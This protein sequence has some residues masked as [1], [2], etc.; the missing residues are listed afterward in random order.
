MEVLLVFI[1]SAVWF[2]LVLAAP[3]VRRWLAEDQRARRAMK[4][5]PRRRVAEVIEGEKARVVG[6]VEVER[7]VTAPLSGRPCAY[8]RVVVEERRSSGDNHYSWE[9]IIDEHGGVDFFLRD[10]EDEALVKTSC[11]QAVLNEDGRFWSGSSDD[12]DP[13]VE[14]SLEAFVATR[15]SRLFFMF[16]KRLRYREGVVEPGELVAAVGVG[17]WEHTPDEQARAGVGYREARLP[18]R[19]VLDAPAE[20]PLLL[21]DE[22]GMTE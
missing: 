12:A 22:V 6:R 18:E 19:L 4:A 14:A 13:Q 9:T 11:V 21:S 15:F 8:W 3:F 20:G 2:V 10:G 7:T 5:V 1:F 16:P 17:R